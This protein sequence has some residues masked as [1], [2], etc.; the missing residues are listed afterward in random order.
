MVTVMDSQN[1]Q[2]SYEG[3]I[4][5][6][7]DHDLLLQRYLDDNWSMESQNEMM[8]WIIDNAQEFVPFLQDY[9]DN[10]SNKIHKVLNEFRGTKSTIGIIIGA[11]DEGKTATGYWFAENIHNMGREIYLCAPSPTLGLPSFMKYCSDPS[12]A[13]PGSCIFMDEVAIQMPAKTSGTERQVV[14]Q[15]QLAI[16]RHSNKSIIFI[17][18]HT[19]LSDINLLRLCDVII[20]KPFSII[21]DETERGFLSKFNRYRPRLKTRTTFFSKHYITQYDQPLASFWNDEEISKS[22]GSIKNEE[23]AI[24]FSNDAIRGG[25]SL[26]E[27]S[28][29]LKTRNFA[30]SKDW[31]GMIADEKNQ[32]LLE[33]RRKYRREKKEVK[34]DDDLV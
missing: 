26:R 27:I 17:T 6:I 5:W 18:Q 15:K 1:R 33:E 4:A 21:Q 29:M 14:L 19:K 30:R 7:L 3:C 13:P 20:L 23:E 25:F 34:K 12:E 11:R 22:W 32:K 10:N 24:K 16:L 9:N 2:I 28:D 31:I 8:E